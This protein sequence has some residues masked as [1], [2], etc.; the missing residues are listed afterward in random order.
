MLK[1]KWREE[2]W[3]PGWKIEWKESH[4]ECLQRELLEEINGDIKD[5]KF[6]KTYE[7]PSF[8]NTERH[9]TQHIYIV[10]LMNYDILQPAH[11]IEK[12][13][14]LSKQEFNDQAY[15]MIPITE[16]KIIPDIIKEGI[17]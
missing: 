16:Q 9:I 15:P 10:T 11:E 4:E 2:L 6:I 17:W 5:M 14:R 12:V 8:Y 1:W 7:W 3:T 13:V